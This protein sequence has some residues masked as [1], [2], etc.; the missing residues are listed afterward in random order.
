MLW[1]SNLLAHRYFMPFNIIFSFL[2]ATILFSDDVNTKLKRSLTLIWLFVLI[3]GNFWIYPPKIAKGWDSTL[4]HLPYF[5][6]RSQAIT[7]LDHEHIN[8]KEIQSFFPNTATLDKI[9]LNDDPRNFD[10]FDGKTKYVFYSNIYNI[11]DASYNK[12]INEYE[13]IK[14]FKNRGVYI[15]IYKRKITK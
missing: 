6:L 14:N 15:S 10:N 2:C 3:S 7:Y 5:N 9:D 4:A 8:F 12:I 13:V 1:A 11:D